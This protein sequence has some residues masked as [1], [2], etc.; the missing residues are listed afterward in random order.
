MNLSLAFRRRFRTGRPS[1]DLAHTGGEGVHAKWEVLHSADDLAR[2]LALV[3]GLPEVVA[4]EADLAPV[5]ALRAVVDRIARG[6][7]D[8][9]PPGGADVAALNAAAA[10]PPLVPVLGGGTTTWADPDGG[11]PAAPAVLATL[12]R[13]A[14]E[15]FGG[16]LAARIKVCAA[17]DCGLLLV[18]TSR[19]GT[20]RWCS[21][22]WCG[23]RAKVRAHRAGG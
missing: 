20:R 17:E 8:G 21:M 19:P 12:A 4:S 1:L 23:N 18:D 11:T 5:K 2:V 7:A 22:E 3:A 16:P 10:R 14:V 15:L 9:R 6:L 13:D